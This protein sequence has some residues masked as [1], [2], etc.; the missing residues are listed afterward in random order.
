[1]QQANK[2]TMADG[3]ATQTLLPDGGSTQQPTDSCVS[4]VDCSKQ[5]TRAGRRPRLSGPGPRAQAENKPHTPSQT[6]CV[7]RRPPY[8]QLR[9]W[10]RGAEYVR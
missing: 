2:F 7:W 6:H 1:M 10:R 5:E 3:G 9:A 4:Q 8:S